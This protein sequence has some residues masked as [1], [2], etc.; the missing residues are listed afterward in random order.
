[1][2]EE[3]TKETTEIVRGTDLEK[4]NGTEIGDEVGVGVLSERGTGRG[5]GTRTTETAMGEEIKSA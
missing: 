5:I 3:E 1:M 2:T 4:E